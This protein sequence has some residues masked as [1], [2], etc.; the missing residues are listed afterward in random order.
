MR[1]CIFSALGVFRLRHFVYAEIWVHNWCKWVH[2]DFNLGA[3]LYTIY[4]HIGYME[5]PAPP[6]P[7]LP[8]PIPL[9]KNQIHRFYHNELTHLKFSA[10]APISK[11]YFAMPRSIFDLMP[12]VTSAFTILLETVN[13]N[14]C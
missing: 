3:Y 4:F 14:F 9:S 11:W 8:E 1:G 7:Q 12:P 13:K 6:Q 5:N 2:F 10:P